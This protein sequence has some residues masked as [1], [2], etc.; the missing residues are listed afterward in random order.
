[1]RQRRRIP[2]FLMPAV[3]L[4][5]LGC[6]V[7]LPPSTGGGYTPT[8]ILVTNGTQTALVVRTTGQRVTYFAVPPGETKE[9]PDDPRE[10]IAIFDQQCQMLGGRD[11]RGVQPPFIVFVVSSA[12]VQQEGGAEPPSANIPMATTIDS[13]C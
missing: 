6:S 9:I 2:L 12:G 7:Q 10:A 4:L 3:A 1:M 13:H 8:R 5:I 11:D